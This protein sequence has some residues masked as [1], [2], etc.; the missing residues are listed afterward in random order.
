MTLLPQFK[1]VYI[2][3]NNAVVRSLD[4][5]C[6]SLHCDAMCIELQ[7]Q[8]SCALEMSGYLVRSFISSYKNFN[9]MPLL[10]VSFLK[11]SGYAF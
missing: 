8:Q 9:D 10:H 5:S 6:H 7:L 4:H 1:I 2:F 3:L 11:L